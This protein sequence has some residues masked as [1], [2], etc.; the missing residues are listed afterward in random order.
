M[1]VVNRTPSIIVVKTHPIAATIPVLTNFEKHQTG[2]ELLTFI[3]QPT[4]NIPA[5]KRSLNWQPMP[6]ARVKAK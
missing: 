4:E 5:T 3:K 6:K 2:D 1:L